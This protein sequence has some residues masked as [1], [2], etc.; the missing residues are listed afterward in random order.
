[1]VKGPTRREMKAEKKE[2]WRKEKAQ[3]II[4]ENQEL[5]EKEEW[6]KCMAHFCEIL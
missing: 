3:A 4:D 6:L 5:C 1:V 2:L